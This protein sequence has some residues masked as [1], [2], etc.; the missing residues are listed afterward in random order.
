MITRWRTHTHIEN[1]KERK[2]RIRELE[3]KLHLE[4]AIQ[5]K[6]LHGEAIGFQWSKR[7]GRHCRSKRRTRKHE[8]QNFWE[9]QEVCLRTWYDNKHECWSCS[10]FFPN[11]NLLVSVLC[12]YSIL[13]RNTN[14]Q[15]ISIIYL[16]W[17]CNY[18]EIIVV[19]G[20]T[21]VWKLIPTFEPS[22]KSCFH[23]LIFMHS[24]S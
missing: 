5:T 21:M 9:L 19:M 22:L 1:Y 23:L 16:Q 24:S 18:L 2:L 13:E 8:E 14:E 20:T 17:H 7:F 4:R 15:K 3:V 6:N 12:S 11:S 10:G